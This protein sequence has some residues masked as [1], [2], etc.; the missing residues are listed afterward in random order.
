M[1]LQIPI[2]GDMIGALTIGITTLAGVIVALAI[3]IKSLHKKSVTM[4]E[5]LI[6]AVKDIKNVGDNMTK[7]VDN[8]SEVVNDL[9]KH[10]LQSMKK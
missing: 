1:I 10:I 9:H 5:K 4:A 6:E 7:A 3:Y 8:N 2:P